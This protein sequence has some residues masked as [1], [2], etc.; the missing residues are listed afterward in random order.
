MQAAPASPPRPVARPVGPGRSFLRFMLAVFY[1]FLA[2]IFAHHGAI[3]LVSEDWTPL[4]EQAMLVFLLLLGYAGLGFILDRQ[5]Q[6]VSQ[7]GLAPRAGFIQEAGIGV[8]IGWA[9]AVVCILPMLLFGSL[10]LHFS[11]SWAN[12]GWLGLDALFFAL[13]TLAHPQ[14]AFRGYP[15]QCAIRAIGDRP[16]ALMLSVLYGIFHALV[17]GASHA[18]MAVSIALGLLLSMA[19]LR[20]RSPSVA[21]LGTRNLAGV[22]MRAP[23]S[24]A[25]RS[26]VTAAIRPSY[27]DTPWH[28]SPS[29]A[30]TS[31]LTVAGSP[32]R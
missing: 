25:C 10:A 14:I 32:L 29:V 5:L 31:V 6:P 1:F 17:P 21:S 9:I 28:P 16:A 23:S 30:E 15:V 27:R 12:F 22:A 26:T 2:R 13:A 7:Q 8:A 20:T 4:V 19:Y 3:G 24:S 18:S 11:P